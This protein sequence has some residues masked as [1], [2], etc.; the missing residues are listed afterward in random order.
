MLAAIL[1]MDRGYLTFSRKEHNDVKNN[2]DSAKKYPS[3]GIL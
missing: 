1:Y 2:I 3:Q